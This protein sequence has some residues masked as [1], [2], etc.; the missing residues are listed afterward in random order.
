MNLS[1][2]KPGIWIVFAGGIVVLL[3]GMLLH[4][5]AFAEPDPEPA[6][7]RAIEL[8]SHS[9]IV[10]DR[11]AAEIWPY[12]VDPS[13]WKQG[14]SLVHH[15]GPVDQRGEVFKA[16]NPQDGSV[17]FFVK[18]V[19]FIPNRRRTVKLYLPDAGNL[20]GFASWTLEEMSGRTEVSYHVYTE[21]LLPPEQLASS[22]PEDIAEL[23]MLDYD[24][25]K[26]RFDREL[27]GLKAL[28]EEK[29]E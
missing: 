3:A 19:E 14:G 18:N 25:N 15:S 11:P 27:E 2:S 26:A 21:T 29:T 23:E 8:N 13:D 16:F 9:A 22:T 6:E 5:T 1:G 10:I 20:I 4:A 28:V 24:T 12:I 7:R 17:M